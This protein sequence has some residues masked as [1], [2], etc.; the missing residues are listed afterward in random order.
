MYSKTRKGRSLITIMINEY[1]ECRFHEV[2]NLDSKR[3]DEAESRYE[4][5]FIRV[6]NLLRDKPWCCD[7]RDDVLSICQAVSDELKQSLLIRKE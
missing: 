1:Q 5:V 3:L 6:R 7:D 4:E 2:D